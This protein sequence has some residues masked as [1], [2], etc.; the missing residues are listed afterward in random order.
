AVLLGFVTLAGLALALLPQADHLWLDWLE[1]GAPAIELAFL[2]PSQREVHRQSREAL[3]RG[4]A[5]LERLR[6][7]QQEVQWGARPMSQEKEERLRQFLASRSEITAGDRMVLRT[8]RA[9]ARERQRWWL[10]L[11]LAAAGGAGA[12]LLTRPRRAT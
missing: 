11:P 1:T 9:R 8:L 2:T 7:I 6:A 3:A 12:F 10:G 4:V 5:E